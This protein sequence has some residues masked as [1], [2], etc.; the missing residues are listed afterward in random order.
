M[1]AVV[2]RVSRAAVR[3]DS[4]VT[5]SI[6]AG[7]LVFLGVREGD[8]AE[9]A[10]AFARKIAELRIFEDAEGRMNLDVQAA[11]GAILCVSQFTL[12][13]DVRRGRRPSFSDAAPGPVAEPIY[14]AFCAAVEALGLRCERGVF[15]AHREV[16]LVNDGPVTLWLDSDDLARPRR[17]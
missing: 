13:G 17:A 5:G 16:D 11:G 8:T 10:A 14:E 2:Q 15:G 1:R 12:Y 4:R 7:L 3:V 6:E 9:D